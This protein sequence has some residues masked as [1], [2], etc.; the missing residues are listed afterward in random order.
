MKDELHSHLDG[1][2]P[3]EP[4]SEAN[5]DEAEAWKNLLSAFRTE[6]PTAPA[7]PWLETREMAEI[8]ALPEPS[9]IKR[10]GNWL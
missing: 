6:F 2:M 10:L 5:Q 9:F 4:L 7:P 8:E 3:I 1:E